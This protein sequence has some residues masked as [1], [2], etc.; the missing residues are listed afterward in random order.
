MTYL[1]HATSR[2]LAF[3]ILTLL[4]SVG[5]LLGD[6]GRLEAHANVARADPAVNSRIDFR[7]Q[8]VTIWFTEPI[9]PDFSSI[10]VLDRSGARVDLGDSAS[11]AADPTQLT[12]SLDVIEPGAYTVAWRN[13]STVDGHSLQGAYVFYFA[14]EPG[15]AP[16]VPEPPLL[17]SPVEPV[18][19]WLVLLAG[20]AL[21]GGPMLQRLVLRPTLAR[22]GLAPETA[23][24]IERGTYRLATIA[25]AGFVLASLA[26]L[27]VQAADAGG[28]AFSLPIRSVLLN[29]GW[30][31]AWLW[32]MGATGAFALALAAHR[33]WLPGLP[34]AL[35]QR[36]ETA[37]IVAG[38]AVLFTL[39][40]ASHAA[41]TREVRL[42]A[43]AADFIHLVAAAAWVGG[44]FHLLVSVRL[45]RAVT[46]ANMRRRA[47]A[48]LTPQF[49]VVAAVSI[50]ALVVTGL[51]STWVQVNVPRAFTTPYGWTLL[52]KI[53]LFVALAAVGAVNLLRLSP[54]LSRDDAAGGWL[55][56]LVSLEVVLGVLVVATVGMLTSIEPARQAQ[57]RADA[58]DGLRLQARDEA[59]RVELVVFPGMAGI[60]TATITV[61]DRNGNPV[62][63]A[64]VDFRVTNIDQ[65]LGTTSYP[66]QAHLEGRYVAHDV[67]LSVAGVWQVEIT[68]RRPDAF[69]AQMAF[70]F[71]AGSA[72]TAQIP[73]SPRT[74]RL[75]SIGGL[76]VLGLV[77]L[78]IG[79]VTKRL[80]GIPA[81]ALPTSGALAL[82]AALLLVGRIPP[83]T[84]ASGNPILPDAESIATGAELYATNCVRCHGVT[85]QGDGR[86]AAG[87][88]PPPL[89]LQIHVPMHPD[90]DIFNFIANGVAGT[91]MPVFS[92]SLTDEQ[93]WH[94][95]NYLR[96]L[97]ENADR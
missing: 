8:R 42:D 80:P 67:S 17:R 12:V 49:S 90:G 26:Q 62:D 32:R 58:S 51:F 27:W 70:R 66:I 35:R 1:Q 74:A 78:V 22:T 95:V 93:L 52:L 60:N 81:P 37:A 16:P 56:R 83:E 6:T 82:M 33:G 30:G 69:D 96:S 41:A 39:T 2:G 5:G 29:T 47:L 91:A 9:A 68:V 77:L 38:L 28:S 89:N 79:R 23:A 87:L 19:R 50:A 18:V 20:L 43:M 94:L 71:D 13:V 4:A 15:A 72:P 44:L 97:T 76:A 36:A 86:D 14:V 57:E 3:L 34:D 48:A 84:V 7:P 64:G 55:R 63:G 45:V 25:V 59:T 10:E 54:R 21:A 46:D 61:R 40:M 24:A 75:L 85:G 31:H 65:G 88:Q 11:N 53:A 73:L 92:E